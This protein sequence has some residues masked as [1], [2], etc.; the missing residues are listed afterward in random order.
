MKCSNC[1]INDVSIVTEDIHT[2]CEY[3]MYIGDYHLDYEE[4]NEE[5]ERI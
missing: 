3:C 4:E 2:E 5:H 1:G